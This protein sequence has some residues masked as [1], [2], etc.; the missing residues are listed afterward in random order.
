[1]I[2]IKKMHIGNCKYMCICVGMFACLHV[3]SMYGCTCI[4]VY[5]F[6]QVLYMQYVYKWECT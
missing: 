6:T 3:G 5:G 4:H 2:T 1:M